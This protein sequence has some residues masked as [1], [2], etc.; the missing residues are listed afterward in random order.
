MRAKFKNNSSTKTKHAPHVEEENSV[1][2]RMTWQEQI[3]NLHVTAHAPPKRRD[4]SHT[5][6]IFLI[7]VKD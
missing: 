2:D 4:F 1:R 6:N 3:L 7:T 5:P